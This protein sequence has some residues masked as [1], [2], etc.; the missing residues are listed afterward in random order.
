[1][2]LNNQ[3]ILEIKEENKKIKSGERINGINAGKM[4]VFDEEIKRINEN[5]D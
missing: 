3:K 5:N 2:K 1:M 4:K